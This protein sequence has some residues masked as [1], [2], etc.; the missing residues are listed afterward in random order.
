MQCDNEP[1]QSLLLKPREAARALSI[2]ERTLWQLTN[3]GKIPSVRFGRNVRYD[4]HDLKRWI[5][6]QKTQ[7]CC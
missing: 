5:A 1:F 7:Q 6:A 2:C 4:P 3:D